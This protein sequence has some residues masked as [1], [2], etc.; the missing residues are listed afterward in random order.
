MVM[1]VL[2]VGTYGW[3]MVMEILTVG[4]DGWKMVMSPELVTLVLFGLAGLLDGFCCLE[5][6]DHFLLEF[7]HRAWSPFPAA[8]SAG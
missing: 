8:L 4:T 6:A 7:G 5:A 3:D 1:E 2:T